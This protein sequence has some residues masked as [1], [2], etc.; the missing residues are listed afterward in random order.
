MAYL[1]VLYAIAEVPVEHKTTGPH[2]IGQNAQKWPVE[3]ARNEKQVETAFCRN[4]SQ[5]IRITL[6]VDSFSPH[7]IPHT[8]LDC[9]QLR[10]I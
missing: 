8:T 1:M 4:G 7:K 5:S 9:Q 10:T 3:E 2:K 6:H